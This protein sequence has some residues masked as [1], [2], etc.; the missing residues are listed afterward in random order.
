MSVPRSGP[1]GP[2][3]FVFPL[4]IYKWKMSRFANFARCRVISGTISCPQQ[5]PNISNVIVLHLL[6]LSL[7]LL[8]LLLLLPT[9]GHLGYYKKIIMFPYRGPNG[10]HI[11][12]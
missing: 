4:G 6:Y 2:Q 12:I 7:P 10:P 11:A 8:L 1:N 3:N 9:P 5:V